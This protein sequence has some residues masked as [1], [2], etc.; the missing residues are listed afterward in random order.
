[1]HFVSKLFDQTILVLSVVEFDQ[2]QIIPVVE[3]LVK[4]TEIL[5]GQA[6]ILDSQTH[7]ISVSQCAV[8]LDALTQAGLVVI[9]LK[10]SDTNLITFA[11]AANLAIFNRSN[12]AIKSMLPP[13]IIT[14][15]LPYL[16]KKAI[17]SGEQF[18]IKDKELVVLAPIK[19]NAE[20]LS[21][22]SI[23]IYASAFGKLFAG[24][25]G[26]KNATIFVQDFHATLVCIAGVYKVFNIIPVRLYQQSVLISL[27]DGI[28]V[29]ST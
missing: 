20:V 28:L 14:G 2:A 10:S 19:K 12:Q 13:K 27:E 4:S 17:K 24:I 18:Y 7:Q 6:V 16:V 8:L 29:F 25:N 23:A 3:D 9:G 26:D 1:M 5:A 22:H 11:N 15:K 21:D